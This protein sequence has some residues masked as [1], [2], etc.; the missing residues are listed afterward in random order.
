MPTPARVPFAPFERCISIT[1]MIDFL[2]D[3]VAN[4][5]MTS[6]QSG[7]CFKE[8]HLYEPNPECISILKLNLH[9]A[10]GK[11]G[12]SAGRVPVLYRKFEA[13]LQLRPRLRSCIHLS[14]N[15]ERPVI[16]LYHR[17]EGQ[18]A[19]LFVCF[20]AILR[21]PMSAPLPASQ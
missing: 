20:S 1:S 19:P 17:R 9:R 7:L 3:I 13:T 6:V 4:I 12:Q 2:I 10:L 15:S 14:R 16:K 8:V 21:L 5:G 18:S 11:H